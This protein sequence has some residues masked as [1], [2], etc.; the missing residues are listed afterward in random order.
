MSI[1]HCPASNRWHTYSCSLL[2]RWIP[3]QNVLERIKSHLERST[4]DIPWRATS[5]DVYNLVK[6]LRTP[7]GN[8]WN[9]RGCLQQASESSALYEI[10]KTKD[11]HRRNELSLRVSLGCW[12][13]ASNRD[14]RH[15]P[16]RTQVRKWGTLERRGRETR[17][18]KRRDT[19]PRDVLTS[20][21][22]HVCMR[23][24]TIRGCKTVKRICHLVSLDKLLFLRSRNSAVSL[25]WLTS[26]RTR[27]RATRCLSSRLSFISFPLSLFLSCIFLSF[28]YVK[29][30]PNS[31]SW[32][33]LFVAHQTW[34]MR[35]RP[36]NSGNLRRGIGE[37]RLRL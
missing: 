32:F 6:S 18:N 2:K 26:W 34:N 33:P 4:V 23:V 37:T 15:R 35:I 27:T 28:T 3:S 22:L 8:G 11:N 36:G 30:N 16:W 24:A 21:R 5:S 10:A 25:L 7:V 31:A 13:L 14:K 9:N 17:K 19:T 29:E 20:A 12:L 1:L